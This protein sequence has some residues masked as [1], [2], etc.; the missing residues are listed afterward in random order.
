MRIPPA[1]VLR[2]FGIAAFVA[3][4]H[5]PAEPAVAPPSGLALNAFRNSEWSA[6]VHLDAPINSSARELGAELSPDGLSLYFGSDRPGGAGDVDLW[7]VR[8][9]C[10]DCAWGAAVNLANL[11]S[12]KSDG[13][14]AFSPDGHL[15]FFSSNRDLGHGGDDIWLCYRENTD[16][17][18]GWTPPINLGS[19]IN[20]SEQETS[21][22]YVPA[23][24]GEGSNL[25]F[26]R[27]ATLA[28]FD[29]YEARVSRDGEV[30]TAGTPVTELN[31][32]ALD[33]DPAISHDGKE[34]YFWSQRTGSFGGPDLWFA[35]RQNAHES[36]SSPEN[37]GAVINTAGSD[38][39][40][41]LSHDGRTLFFS[42]G[43]VARGGLGLTDI[44]MSTRTPSGH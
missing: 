1:K 36:W 24:N 3:C 2:F 39:T 7:A 17:D 31:S 12:P 28:G 5:D 10:L 40:P 29:I 33:G 32:S 15:L 21:P 30:L 43:F 26:A 23:L 44:W 8:R 11:N 22:A 14:P 13:G 4:S 42:V 34:I 20:T 25:Y 9:E 37:V 41:G 6:P 18:L 19:G 38:L 35:T 16:D 27:G